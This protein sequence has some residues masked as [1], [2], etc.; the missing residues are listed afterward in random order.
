MYNVPPYGTPFVVPQPTIPTVPQQ[1]IQY[2]TS[3][4]SAD[5]YN[6]APNTSVVLFNQNVDEFY[7]VSA[8][9]SGTKTR[10]DYTF[11]LKEKEPAPE[12]VTKQ[13]LEAFEQRI[14]AKI[15]GAKDEQPTE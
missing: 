10:Q 11:K 2:V 5:A 15:G 9:A 6:L 13:E 12:Y 14:L 8:D 3:P 1:G 7:M 4:E